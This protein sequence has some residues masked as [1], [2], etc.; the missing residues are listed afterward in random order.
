MIKVIAFD[1]DDTLTVSKRPM[2]ANMAALIKKLLGKYE[3][4]IIS[5]TN[6]EVM[7]VNDIDVLQG[8]GSI[9]DDDVTDDELKHLHVMATTGTQYWH[10]VDGDWKREYAHFLTDEEVTKVSELLEKAS[11]KLGYWCENPAGEI[12]ENRGSQVTMSA[13]GQLADPEDKKVWDPDKSKR[14]AI[15]AEVEDEVSAMGL[16]ILS[17]GS[18]SVDVVKPGIDKAY[19]MRQ[20]M[21]QLGVKKEEILFVGDRLDP[22]GNDY[23][24]KR[25]GFKTIAVEKWEDTLYVIEG[26]LGVTD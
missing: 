18:T 26:I 8:P 12:I 9:L 10:F 2:T 6:W 7:K 5:G 17:G 20:L 19:G 21:E 15:K 14:N 25:D 16:E 3:V 13:L 1:Q 24:V 4:C 22:E 11:R 23:A